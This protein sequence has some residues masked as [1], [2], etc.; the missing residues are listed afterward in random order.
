M[1]VRNSSEFVVQTCAPL[2]GTRAG[3]NGH[4][5]VTERVEGPYRRRTYQG[6][7]GYQ[8]WASDCWV[9]D[10]KE[11]RIRILALLAG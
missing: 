9:S 10:T 8:M 1:I 5:T 4:L 11:H 7:G 3:V 6:I 2:P